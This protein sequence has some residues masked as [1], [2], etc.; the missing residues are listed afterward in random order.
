[1]TDQESVRQETPP[2]ALRVVCV[3]F[4][5]FTFGY[6][7]SY[8]F[9]NVN[10]VLF[11]HLEAD[12]GVTAGGL[13]LLTAAYFLSFAAFQLPL[14]MLLDRFGPRRVEAVLLLFAATGAFVFSVA[15]SLSVL[16]VGR[17]LI[18]FG[19]S[20]C[21]MAA[22]KANVIW[23]PAERLPLINGIFMMTGG[24]GAM[25]GTA[26][27]EAIA[28]VIDWRIVFQALAGLTLLSAA[29]I[30]FVVPE[31]GAAVASG[32]MRHAFA[33]VLEVWTSRRFW[34]VAP[35]T[36]LIH[37]AFL[38]YQGFWVGPWLRDVAGLDSA[39]VGRWV[40][41][42]AVLLTVGY[43]LSAVLADRLRGRENGTL[44][45]LTWFLF[46]TVAAQG[47]LL[48]A[49][50]DWSAVLWCFFSFVGTGSILSYAA[51][52]Q[53]Y[54]PEL[55]GRVTTGLNLAV[56]ITAF[57]M[58]AGIGWIIDQFTPAAGQ[59]YAPEGHMAAL[60]VLLAVQAAGFLWLIWSMRG[61]E[62]AR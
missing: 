48:A 51:L 10:S 53:L 34:R 39:S 43:G 25:M 45:V 19:V 7:L 11:P 28:A 37:G 54:A 35:A 13:G 15:E 56:F 42:T 4:L 20:A 40:F 60:A 3:V 50:P 24:L 21:L 41:A 62:Q 36:F 47:A 58:Q 44:R 14:G 16:F 17:L 32:G 38:N 59:V 30:F 1:M 2:A 5:P 49:P 8:L 57:C 61:R 6:F 12:I 23:W 18:G 52:T 46:L 26:P 31:R 9:R 33:G 29:T 22:F 27:I 55:S